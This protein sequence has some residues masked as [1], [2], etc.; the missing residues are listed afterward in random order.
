MSDS[1]VSARERILA[2]AGGCFAKQGFDGISVADIAAASGV[3]TGLVYYHFKDKAALY[4]SVVREGLLLLEDTAVRTL[5]SDERP[6]D[7]IRAFIGEYMSLLDGQPALM[8][9]F[10]RSVTDV[11]TLPPGHVLMR[12]ATTID[13]LQAVI[14]EGIACAEFRDMD[15]RLAATALFALVNTLIT[16]RVLETPP[17]DDSGDSVEVRAE[18]M[19]EL[20]LRGVATCS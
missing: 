1:E 20:F 12:S 9:L 6:L 4:E 5:D 14:D 15:S 16:A 11:S 19:A 8:Q 10:I 3:S 17:G 13:R 7:R 2:T 18:F